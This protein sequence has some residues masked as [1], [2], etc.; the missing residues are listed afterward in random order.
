MT[1]R[2]IT[3]NGGAEVR[4]DG[5]FAALVT[6]QCGKII[7]RRAY[8]L[9]ERNGFTDGHDH[10]HWLEGERELMIQDVPLSRKTKMPTRLVNMQR[11]SITSQK[12][13]DAVVAA[14]EEEIGRPNM[15]EFV[16][17][18]TAA[19]SYDE[20][21]KVVHDSVSEIGL[22]EFM[23]LDHGAVLR[24]AGGDGNRKSVRLIVGNPL[25]MQSMTRLVPDAG[26]YAPVT[27]LID[28]RPDGVHLSY[29]EMA[30]VLAPYGNAEAL[31]IAR[32]LDAKVK[33]LL[34]S[35]S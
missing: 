18:M 19:T 5:E 2:A 34:K 7:E 9:S 23:R 14:V 33:R 3:N 21:Q 1:R 15:L 16:A 25:I 20:M 27:V 28:Q 10:E 30:S 8:T 26:S 13:F 24:K 17:M 4:T 35:A 6:I 12:P 11:W 22:M 29:D 32:D 31:K